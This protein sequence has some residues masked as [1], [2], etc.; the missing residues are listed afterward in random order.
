[1][2]GDSHPPTVRES[3]I[4]KAMASFIAAVSPSRTVTDPLHRTTIFSERS[5]ADP[6]IFSLALRPPFDFFPPLIIMRIL[7]IA[8][9]RIVFLFQRVRA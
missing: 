1:M 5:R 2:L 9:I 8:I 4:N 6:V 3:E 7:P